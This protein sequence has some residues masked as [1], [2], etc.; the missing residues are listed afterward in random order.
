MAY[1]SQGRHRASAGTASGEI[2]TPPCGERSDSTLLLDYRG[3]EQ[4]RFDDG[5]VD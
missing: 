4:W 2:V 3:V 5:R 1:A